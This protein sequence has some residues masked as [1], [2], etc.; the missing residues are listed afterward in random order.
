LKERYASIVTNSVRRFKTGTK[1]DSIG[2]WS[3]RATPL[4]LAWWF[5]AAG[6]IFHSP[7]SASRCQVT[8]PLIVSIG[9]WSFFCG[10]NIC[11]CDLVWIFHP[12]QRQTG[13]R[14]S[15]ILFLNEFSFMRRVE[16]R[17]QG[18]IGILPVG[19][20]GRP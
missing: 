2:L 18:S 1:G 4:G 17:G 19:R 10:F 16:G 14:V 6:L 11:C 12:L 9:L 8:S 15:G 13:L 20:G 5:S 3:N 7:V